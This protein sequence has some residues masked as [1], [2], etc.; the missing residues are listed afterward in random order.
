MP[1]AHRLLLLLLALG[2]AL[3]TALAAHHGFFWD[4]VLQASR[5][6]QWYYDTH[7]HYLLVPE[8]L[9]AGHP[10]LFA[11]ALAAV[12]Q[13][14]GR[15]LPAGHWAML[16]LV[17]GTL[18]QVYCLARRF[19]P[20]AW[21]LPAV[22]LMWLDATWLTQTVLVTPDLALV[23]CYLL[24]LN[25]LT[26]R[27]AGL[28]VAG[29]LP[30]VLLSTRGMV[31][32]GSLALTAA[33][34]SWLDASPLPARGS[35]LAAAVRRLGQRLWPLLPALALALGWLLMHYRLR[36]W[37]GYNL[38]SQWAGN[39]ARLGPAGVLRNVGLIG[40]RLLDQGR[41]TLWLVGAG[42]L[43]VLWRGGWRPGRPTWQLLALVLPPALALTGVLV[44]YANPIGHRYYL[45][46]YLLVA[47]LVAHLLNELPARRFARL[48]AAAALLGLLSGHLWVYP[49]HMANGWD[50]TLAHWPYYRLRHRFIGWL[51][52]RRIP[53]AEVGS[54]FPNLYPL[55]Q[56]DLNDDPRRFA[57]VDLH[58]NRYVLQSNTMNFGDAVLDSLQQQWQLRHEERVG[59]V[60]FRLYER[61][62]PVR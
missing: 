34:L 61:P 17:L 44:W 24:A 27:R 39:Y 26:G 59:Q 33:F 1:T 38:H 25:G 57:P 15:S 30:L 29:A 2:S 54:N 48:L 51:D 14:L 8:S 4:A 45:P 19:M 31:L 6:A 28:V 62:A 36:G 5:Q 50:A 32:W 11:A 35:P 43:L 21:V 58:R 42:T 12:W 10:T 46:V 22:L 37:V 52:A 23:F 41:V 56:V 9:D 18:W 20:R 49:D 55:A 7:F 53:L 3:L 13:L 47:L 40:W 60:Y 16:P